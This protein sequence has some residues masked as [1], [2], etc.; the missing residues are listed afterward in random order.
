MIVL[1]PG[2]LSTTTDCPQRSAS[3]FAAS[4]AIGSVLPPGG[5]GTIKRI[6]LVGYACWALTGPANIKPQNDNANVTIVENFGML[7]PRIRL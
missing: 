7:L 1:P 6:D 2:R 5:Y 3:L 4:R